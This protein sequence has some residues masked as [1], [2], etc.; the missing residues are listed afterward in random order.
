MQ[1]FERIEKARAKE[2]YRNWLQAI[3]TNEDIGDSIDTTQLPHFLP[4]PVPNEQHTYCQVCM[5]SYDDYH[6]HI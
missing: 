6:D 3:E 5:E 4:E 2:T 1:N